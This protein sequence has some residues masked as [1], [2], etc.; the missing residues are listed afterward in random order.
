[1]PDGDFVVALHLADR[2]DPIKF[3]V[4][5]VEM[6]EYIVGQLTDDRRRETLFPGSQP[7]DGPD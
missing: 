5:P 1:M 2:T 6:L 4:S 3:L 7:L